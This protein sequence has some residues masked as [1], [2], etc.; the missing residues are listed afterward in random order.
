MSEFQGVDNWQ[1]LFKTNLFTEYLCYPNIH[2]NISS[3]KMMTDF[4][5]YEIYLCVENIG[6]LLQSRE[7]R[8]SLLAVIE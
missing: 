7:A 2:L 6:E 4:L 1:K 5:E 3:P 8:V